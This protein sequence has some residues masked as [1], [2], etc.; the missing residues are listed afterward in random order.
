MPSGDDT[1]PTIRPIPFGDRP[2]EEPYNASE[3]RGLQPHSAVER[4]N[5]SWT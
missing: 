5:T 3:V 1:D 2:G 4:R